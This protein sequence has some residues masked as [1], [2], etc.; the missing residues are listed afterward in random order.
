MGQKGSLAG[1]WSGRRLRLI[2]H[3][4]IQYEKQ[5]ERRFQIL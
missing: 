4:V 2:R 1:V 5:N 3:G